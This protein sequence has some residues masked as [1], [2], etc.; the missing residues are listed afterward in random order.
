MTNEL[1]KHH[2]KIV[3]II[4][5]CRTLK[6]FQTCWN[7]LENFRR[8][9]YYDRFGCPDDI[10]KKEVWCLL[11]GLLIGRVAIVSKK[12]SNDKIDALKLK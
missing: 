11:Y 8:Y 3:T 6:Q 4:K 9:P 10:D 2:N 5:S 1:R 7:I 12:K